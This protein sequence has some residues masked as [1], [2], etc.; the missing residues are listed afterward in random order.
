MKKARAKLSWAAF[1]QLHHHAVRL[2]Y[3]LWSTAEQDTWQGLSV[4]AID[5]SKCVLPASPALRAAFDPEGGLDQPGPGHDPQCLLSTV[6][7]VFRHGRA[8]VT[9]G[10]CRL[11]AQS[12]SPCGREERA[13]A[14]SV[15]PRAGRTDANECRG[16]PGPR[17]AVTTFIVGM[18]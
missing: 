7:D 14:R 18:S 16:V 9:A 3:E 6:Q 5:G 17:T 15:A 8:F 12:R 2:A 10:G 13:S 4:S 11:E 1:G